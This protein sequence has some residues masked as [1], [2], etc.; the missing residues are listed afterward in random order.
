M[1]KDFALKNRVNDIIYSRKLSIFSRSPVSLA[2]HV[3]RL[4]IEETVSN[5]V[6][7]TLDRQSQPS[8]VGVGWGVTFCCKNQPVVKCYTG[9]WTWAVSIEQCKQQKLTC[10]LELVMPGRVQVD[11]YFQHCALSPPPFL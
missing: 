4:Q 6:A 5:V 9:P 8:S 1:Q 2:W 7:N 3:S 10:Y 11:T